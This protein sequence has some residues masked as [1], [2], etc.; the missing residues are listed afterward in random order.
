MTKPKTL[1]RQ[2]K[3]NLNIL[4]EREAKYGRDV[5]LELL[6]Q[7]EDHDQAIMLTEQVLAGELSEAAWQEALQPLLLAVQS[8]QVVT[9]EAE[10]Y[11]AGSVQGDVVRRDKVLGDKIGRDKIS[12]T[13]INIGLSE[14][15]A[16][17]RVAI[18][19]YLEQLIEDTR[20]R[21]QSESQPQSAAL[22]R[23]WQQT[24][25]VRRPGQ[26]TLSRRSLDQA[27]QDRLDLKRP[28]GIVRR[29][30]ALLADAGVGKTPAFQYILIKVAEKSLPY[31]QLSSKA[32][33]QEAYTLVPILIRL[34]ELRPGQQLLTLVRTAYNRHAAEAISL[35]QTE[36]LLETYPCLLMIDDLDKVAFGAQQGGIQLI[37]EFM[38]NYPQERY[39][40][41]CRTSGYHEQLGPMDA[42]ILD[43]LTEDQ[44]R[45]VLAE[46]FDARLLPLAR[47]RAMLQIL[48]TGGPR[49]GEQWSRG[50]LVQRMVGNQLRVSHKDE[51]EL[52]LE[53]IEAMLEQLSYQMHQARLYHQTEQQLMTFMTDHLTAWHEPYSWRQVIRFLRQNGVLVQDDLHQWR[54]CNRSTQAYFV[55]ATIYRDQTLLA[56]LLQNVSDFW[57]REPLE[58]LVGLL[59]DPSELLF[60]MIDYDALVTAHCLQFVGQPVEQRVFNAL[61]DALVEQMRHERAA[62][63]ER[64]VR[65]LTEIGQSPPQEL[66]WQL[67][68]RER[69]SLVI[70]VIAQA[71]ANPNHISQSRATTIYEAEVDEIEINPDLKEI[72]DLWQAHGRTTDNQSKDE[73]EQTLATRLQQRRRQQEGLISGL[74]AIALGFIGIDPDRDQA[75]QVLLAELQA[76]HQNQF[77]AWCTVEAL[78]QIKHQEVEQAAIALYYRRPGRRYSQRRERQR[79]Y[80]IYL[81]GAVGGRFGETVEILN[82]ALE[83]PNPTLRGYAARS[84]GRL[85]LLKAREQLESRLESK[86]RQRR[87]QNPWVLRRI[88]EAL[89]KV[90]T[91]ES[92]PVLEPYLRH[93]EI[94]TRRRVREAITEIR[95]RYELA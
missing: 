42:F 12:H 77:I 79:I 20:T 13:Q 69:K 34:A 73:I 86:D 50:R 24:F 67:L 35:D 56:G 8:G 78:S 64:L 65:L 41:S 27:I 29:A 22:Q 76:N 51:A 33:E 71:L 57:W 43:E 32:V 31:Y 49:A 88:V 72:I 5:P 74:A 70:L 9:I 92:I 93:E 38:D 21:Q 63:R 95:R 61:V 58:I 80:A 59:D 3:K 46:A 81:L 18:A 25:Y 87:E 19:G 55:A 91:L 62:G 23:L 75:R 37:R 53:M 66:F 89:S 4:R 16:P 44:V 15:I 82:Q 1:L 36:K 2:L 39:V 68:Y 7:L 17:D 45:A 83:E 48:L 10:T 84:V 40:I 60:N 47:N 11:I 54:F 14:I 85:G 94:R 28:A 90:G 30:V 52:D 6:N 26:T